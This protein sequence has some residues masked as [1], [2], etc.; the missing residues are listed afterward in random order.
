MTLAHRWT[1]L[2]VF[3]LVALQFLWHG[4]LAP[5]R[6]PGWV[7][8]AIASLPLLAALALYLPRG[9]GAAVASGM[10][11]L[12]YFAHGVTEA[13]ADPEVRTLALLEAGLA[14]WVV[15]CSSWDG[16][17]ARLARKPPAA[18]PPV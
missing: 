6:G 16:L 18:P 2:G 15:F 4:W 11:A 3:A 14:T 5:P 12:L 8:A 7:L 13:W 1:V 17:R 10:V 9:R